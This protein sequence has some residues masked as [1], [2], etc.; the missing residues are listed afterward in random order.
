MAT[1]GVLEMQ[2]LELGML[3]RCA[4]ETFCTFVIDAFAGP[5]GRCG[6]RMSTG[7]RTGTPAP[8]ERRSR[9]KSTIRDLREKESHDFLRASRIGEAAGGGCGR[10]GAEEQIPV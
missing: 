5:P 1:L 8:L 3:E 9:L 4:D 7:R 10:M 6:S 2:L